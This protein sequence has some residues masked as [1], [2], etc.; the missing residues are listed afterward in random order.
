LFTVR[1]ITLALVTA[2]NNDYRLEIKKD[3]MPLIKRLDS[4]F[5]SLEND[6]MNAIWNNYKKLIA[7]TDEYMQTGFEEGALPMSMVLSENNFIF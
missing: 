3:L 2:P 7:I 4:S 6:E 5:S 1:E